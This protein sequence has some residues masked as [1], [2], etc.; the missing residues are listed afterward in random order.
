M[1]TF[2]ACELSRTAAR[3]VRH[4]RKQ[5]DWSQADLAREAG[6]SRALVAFHETGRRNFTLTVLG[7]VATALG[8]APADLLTSPAARAAS[9]P[10]KIVLTMSAPPGMSPAQVSE[11]GEAFARRFGSARLS[12]PRR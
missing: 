3:N 1:T 5:R 7:K 11:I 8:V 4:L 10:P 2:E 6:I 9:E 12:T